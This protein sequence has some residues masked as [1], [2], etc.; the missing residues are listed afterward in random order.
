M[1]FNRTD[2]LV[3]TL[4]NPFLFFVFFFIKEWATYL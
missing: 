3:P 2:T 4:I 1:G